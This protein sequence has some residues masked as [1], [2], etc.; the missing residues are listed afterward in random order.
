MLRDAA[1]AAVCV[2]PLSCAEPCTWRRGTGT[3]QCEVVNSQKA[4]A[5]TAV[6]LLE[7]KLMCT[8]RGEARNRNGPLPSNR[9]LLFP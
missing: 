9:R 8:M 5:F 2:G 3:D 1:A 4:H 7:L 6:L